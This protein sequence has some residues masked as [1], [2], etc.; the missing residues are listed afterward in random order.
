MQTVNLRRVTSLPAQLEQGILYL[1][2]DEN[3]SL[4]VV[5]SDTTGEKPAVAYRKVRLSGPREIFLSGVA[6]FTANYEIVNYDSFTNY[7]ATI[8]AGS[9]V[10]NDNI[11]TV[12]APEVAGEIYLSV[13]G[14]LSKITVRPHGVKEPSIEYPG[15]SDVLPN[16][17]TVF[18]TPFATTDDSDTFSALQ[19]R[20]SET[21]DFSSGVLTFTENMSDQEIAV[22]G[23]VDNRTYYLQARH[24]GFN[25]GDGPWSRSIRIQTTNDVAGMQETFSIQPAVTNI[26]DDFSKHVDISTLGDLVLIASPWAYNTQGAAYLS[27]KLNGSWT[28]TDEFKLELGNI[29][30]ELARSI[31]ISGDGTM[32][33]L[34][35]PGAASSVGAVYTWTISG[36]TWNFEGELSPIDSLSGSQFGA[37]VALSEDGQ[38][39]A[40]GSLYG[41]GSS[42]QT[43]CVHVYVRSGGSWTLEQK[44]IGSTGANGDFFG[45]SVDLSS[46]GNTLIVGAIHDSD[47]A[48]SAGSAYVYRRDQGTWSQ[49]SKLTSAVFE[50]GAVFGF[51]VALSN[52][53]NTAAVSSLGTEMSPGFI[54]IFEYTSSWSQ[55]D[56][57]SPVDA[58]D[59]D[60][61]G[62]SL[63]LSGT[64]DYLLAGCSSRGNQAGAAYFFTKGETD[65]VESQKVL[66][67]SPW[68]NNLFGRS[69]ALS[70]DGSL[71]VIGRYG[72]GYDSGAAYIF[73]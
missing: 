44:L 6:P 58:E 66:E 14:E 53:G 68:S 71:A 28:I 20:A 19:L 7:T 15:T 61:F 8:S 60:N 21:M 40:V 37:S 29:G 49:Q 22:S 11:I 27:K 70:D 55:V 43:G 45:Y 16:S 51:K 47:I 63:A 50:P 73:E 38:T 67:S 31:A 26:A 57:L 39:M 56:S 65:W 42:S 41:N 34:G 13:N 3:D 32:V 62:V 10:I 5:L 23:L 35:A 12:T 46:D 18:V 33:V 52:D 69:V 48:A 64:G 24:V 25:Y 54:H 72:H 1:V 59:S 30:D 36:K 9:V 4:N 2:K 17:F